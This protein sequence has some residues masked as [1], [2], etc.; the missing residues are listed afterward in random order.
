MRDGS[1][2]SLFFVDDVV[3]LASSGGDLQLPL[4]WFTAW[5]SEGWIDGSLNTGVM[6]IIGEKTELPIFIW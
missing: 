1:I 6:I 2:S 5:H 4:Q 3:L